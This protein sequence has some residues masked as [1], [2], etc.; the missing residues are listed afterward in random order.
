M[1]K[2]A[3]SSACVVRPERL[4]ELSACYL[5]SPGT[6]LVP[7][8]A[9]HA[10]ARSDAAQD[11]RGVLTGRLQERSGDPSAGAPPMPIPTRNLLQK[12]TP[13]QEEALSAMS[14]LALASTVKDTSSLSLQEQRSSTSS[15]EG[16]F[17]AGRCHAG[18]LQSA[19]VPTGSL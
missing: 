8:E 14:L 1:Y 4:E 2:R 16:R 19:D 11:L 18:M 3:V 15:R 10:G 17:G 12:W 7:G 9:K 13:S 5:S 6:L